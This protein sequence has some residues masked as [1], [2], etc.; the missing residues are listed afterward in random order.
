MVQNADKGP[1][2]DLWNSAIRRVIHLLPLDQ[3]KR[4]PDLADRLADLAIATG[5][6]FDEAARLIKV[7]MMPVSR[8]DFGSVAYKIT[9][10][11]LPERFPITVLDL[12]AAIIQTGGDPPYL[13]TEASRLLQRVR[14]TAPESAETPGYRRLANSGWFDLG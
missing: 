10:S 4:S 12:L 8:R 7:F 5:D 13:H 1:G 11:D 6:S 3:E 2:A 14:A 9:K